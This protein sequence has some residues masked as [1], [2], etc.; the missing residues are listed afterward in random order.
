MQACDGKSYRCSCK[1]GRQ[2]APATYSA[3]VWPGRADRAHTG[4]ENLKTPDEPQTAGVSAA[5]AA[6]STAHHPEQAEAAAQKPLLRA[7]TA[8]CAAIQQAVHANISSQCVTNGDASGRGL[9]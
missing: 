9:S 2:A 8:V 7:K 5:S 4:P 6:A 3:Q 1:R